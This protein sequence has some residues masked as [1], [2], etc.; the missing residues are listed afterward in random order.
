[1]LTRLPWHAQMQALIGPMVSLLQKAT[2]AEISAVTGG[3]RLLAALASAELAAAE[4][5]HGPEARVDLDILWIFIGEVRCNCPTVRQ[6]IIISELKFGTHWAD[7]NLLQPQ[8]VQST[9]P[10]CEGGVTLTTWGMVLP[11]GERK[12]PGPHLIWS[13]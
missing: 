2:V 11:V 9:L 10:S 5:L 13:S 3:G 4:T 8:A 6:C 1:M 12:W 7:T